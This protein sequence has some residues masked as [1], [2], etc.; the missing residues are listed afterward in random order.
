MR[1]NGEI[2]EGVGRLMWAAR[3]SGSFRLSSGA[4]AQ[5]GAQFTWE[6]KLPPPKEKTPEPKIIS[7]G[8][9]SPVRARAL[10]RS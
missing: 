4:E 8:A 7:S 2:P 3:I 10:C 5:C 6:L 1:V 9:K